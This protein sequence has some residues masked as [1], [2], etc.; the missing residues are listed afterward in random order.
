[1]CI[2][3]GFLQFDDS[4]VR[5]KNWSEISWRSS[6]NI[7]AWTLLKVNFLQ[8]L[9][10]S[11]SQNREHQKYFGMLLC[12]QEEADQLQ[13]ATY[14]WVCGFV[15]CSHGLKFNV[16]GHSTNISKILQALVVRRVDNTIHQISLSHEH[17]WG[18]CTVPL[19]RQLPSKNF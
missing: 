7:P 16:I 9:L 13:A 12:W 17:P 10:L 11:N 2:F 6:F 3:F 14:Y 19:E 8:C 1:M 18:Y 15:V 4:F 5:H